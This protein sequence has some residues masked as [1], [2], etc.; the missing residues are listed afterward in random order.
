MFPSRIVP[1]VF[2]R[3]PESHLVPLSMVSAGDLSI[4]FF[5]TWSHEPASLSAA[6]TAEEDRASESLVQNG[7]LVRLDQQN[8]VLRSE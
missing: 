4:L 1:F 3:D 6:R 7:A 8:V 5:P 2:K